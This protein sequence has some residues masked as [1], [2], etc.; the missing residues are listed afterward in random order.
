[1]EADDDGLMAAEVMGTVKD[2]VDTVEF[3]RAR[4]WAWNNEPF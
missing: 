1:M 4:A 3:D 2:F